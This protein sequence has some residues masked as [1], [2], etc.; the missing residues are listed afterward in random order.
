MNCTV[1]MPPNLAPLEWRSADT[2]HGRTLIHRKRAS[3]EKVYM[4]LMFVKPIPAIP[5]KFFPKREPR[6]ETRRTYQSNANAAPPA[7]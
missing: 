6:R 2:K 3:R 1:N 7:H 5:A 4:D